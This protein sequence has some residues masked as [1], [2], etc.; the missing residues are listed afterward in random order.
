MLIV[1]GQKYPEGL[2]FQKD[3]S[4]RNRLLTLEL[5]ECVA[6]LDKVLPQEEQPTDIDKKMEEL[7]TKLNGVSKYKIV[8]D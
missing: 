6:I 7:T 1:K 3:I 4:L 5:T 2:T 8:I